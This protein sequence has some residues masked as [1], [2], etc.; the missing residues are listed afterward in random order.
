MVGVQTK[1]TPI[2]LFNGRA[3][4]TW[5]FLLIYLIRTNF[6]HT[7]FRAFAQKFMFLH[8]N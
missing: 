6:A 2:T 5:V 7:N 1:K 8:E 3:E 4:T